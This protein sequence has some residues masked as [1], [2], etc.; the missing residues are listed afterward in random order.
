MTRYGTVEL[1]DAAN[2]HGIQL[3]GSLRDHAAAVEQAIRTLESDSLSGDNDFNTQIAVLNKINATGTIALRAGQDTN[4]LLVA[5]LEQRITDS[6]RRRDAEAS[7]IN[8]HI[9]FER[10]AME[11]GMDGIRG[12]TEA[13]QSF[14]LP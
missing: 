9:A 12:T 3:L 14:R 7:A 5:L 4:K 11:I 6:K 8:T 1:A 10:E 2:L 13:L